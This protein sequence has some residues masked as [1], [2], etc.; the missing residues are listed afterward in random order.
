MTSFRDILAAP[1]TLPAPAAP[2]VTAA[3]TDPVA[4]GVASIA[5]AGPPPAPANPLLLSPQR[6]TAAI[7]LAQQETWLLP[8][9]RLA[10]VKLVREVKLADEYINLESEEMWVL[11]VLEM[12]RDFPA[13]G[14]GM[15]V[16]LPVEWGDI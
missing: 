11:W 15:V 6:R 12:F 1:T 13:Q 7:Q 4:P 5:V 8:V 9:Q 10:L 16:P 14:R 3:V 2:V